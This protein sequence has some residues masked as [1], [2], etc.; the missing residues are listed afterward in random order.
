[1][2]TT[3]EIEGIALAVNRRVDEA[4][5][6]MRSEQAQAL[7]RAREQAEQDRR[8]FAEQVAQSVA[9]AERAEARLD[10]VQ[11]D[12]DAARE[13][14]ALPS[15]AA[16]VMDAS[17][18]LH[19]VMRNGARVEARIADLDSLVENRV[20]RAL[21][22]A[23]LRFIARMDSTMHEAMQRLGN[24]P[25]WTRLA[26]YRAGSV[27]SCYMGRTY[28]VRAGVAASMAQ[29]PGLCP[30]VWER[31]GSHGL[32]VM[33][34][35]PDNLEVGDVYK[36]GESLFI[37]DGETSYL[38]VPRGL[39]QS[40]LDRQIKPTHALAQSAH[41]KALGVERRCDAWEPR[42]DHTERAANDAQAWIATEGDEAV[43]R[44]AQTQAWID[45]RAP[46]IDGMLD[47]GTA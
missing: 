45:V 9:R 27:V 47:E 29:E 28:V 19:I 17:G 5:G 18:V 30:E 16:A 4:V 31:I 15:I 22:E 24:A 26:V 11:R 41:D 23:E 34:S 36:E 38:F 43:M 7:E 12:L 2:M 14:A 44:S 35:K 46:L 8:E 13:L 10:Q 1:M 25:K 21:D 20:S 39:K 3:Q 40:D 6:L 33:K 42:L 37:F 32:R